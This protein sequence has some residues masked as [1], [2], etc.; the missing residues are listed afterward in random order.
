MLAEPGEVE[1]LAVDEAV[2]SADLDGPDAERFRIAVYH[3]VAVEKLYHQI[4]KIRCAR[5]P[6]PDILD[7]EGSVASFRGCD[8]LSCRVEG[9]DADTRFMARRDGI[10][11]HACFADHVSD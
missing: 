4:V 3:L 5:L 6:Q 2:V 9:S 11:D 7:A 10:P 1:G 8:L